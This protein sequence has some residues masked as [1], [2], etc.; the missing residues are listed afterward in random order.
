MNDLSWFEWE[1]DDPDFDSVKTGAA[2]GGWPEFLHRILNEKAGQ[3]SPPPTPYVPADE[4]AVTTNSGLPI[5]PPVEPP[6]GATT[7]RWGDVVLATA[8]SRGLSPRV[9]RF[10]FG[11]QEQEFLRL[12]KATLP[13]S[14]SSPLSGRT[15]EN[16][17]NPHA[18]NGATVASLRS[19]IA[20]RDHY[21]LNLVVHPLLEPLD[22]PIARHGSSVTP[23]GEGTSMRFSL[24][25]LMDAAAV[26]LDAQWEF[27]GQ[28]GVLLI[29][30]SLNA[31]IQICCKEA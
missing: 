14:Y 4:L 31:D 28:G 30:S 25:E 5:F 21:G 20:N 23:S 17:A 27:Y 3:M 18:F 1:L 8:W 22:L 15:V 11:D 9:S 6:P 7:L 10:T 29:P 2:S 26:A 16:S 24:F 19:H 12:T 13:L